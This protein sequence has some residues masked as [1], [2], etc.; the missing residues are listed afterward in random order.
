MYSNDQPNGPRPDDSNTGQ[1]PDEIDVVPTVSCATCGQKW[2]LR[3]E[4]DEL[5]VGNQAVEQFALDH[6]RHT[7]H[8]P[9]DV[10]PWIA[11]CRQCPAEEQYLTE[12][13]ARRFAQTHARHTSHTVVLEAPNEKQRIRP[14]DVPGAPSSPEASGEDSSV[15]DQS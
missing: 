9:D 5:M 15:G 7:G 13:P 12:R 11:S 14:E 2:N 3:Y 1:P 4:L 10:T 6:H 8:F